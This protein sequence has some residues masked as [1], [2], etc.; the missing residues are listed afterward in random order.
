MSKKENFKRVLLE[1]VDEGLL[2]FGES[3][4]EAVYFHLQNLYDVKKEEIPVKLEEFANGLR[5]IFGLG[6]DVIE[7]AIIKSLY[8]KIGMKHEEKRVTA[9]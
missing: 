5:K 9:F 8:D 2:T 6:A 7:K 4:R 1:A 3:G